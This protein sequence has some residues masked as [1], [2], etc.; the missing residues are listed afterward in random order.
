MVDPGWAVQ[1]S[2]KAVLDGV[3]TAGVYDDV[4]PGAAYPY[5]VFERQIVPTTA[6]EPLGK[7]RRSE[8]LLYLSIWSRYAG[9]KE[10]LE[11]IS[12]IYEAVH[13]KRL[14]LEVGTMIRCFVETTSTA[15]DIDGET[16]QG[17]VAL[18]V[19]VEH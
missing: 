8:R 3:L 12:D 11:I 10:V 9:Q 4:P 16:M 15:R 13:R 17:Q 2:I 7:T 14:S 1:K 5:V 18:R 6:V 19:I